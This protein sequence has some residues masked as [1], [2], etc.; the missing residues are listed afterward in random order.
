MRSGINELLGRPIQLEDI[1]D[2]LYGPLQRDEST[3]VTAQLL[4]T[5]RVFAD[6]AENIMTGKEVAER[7]WQPT[8]GL[9]LRAEEEVT[10]DTSHSGQHPKNVLYLVML[11]GVFLV[12]LNN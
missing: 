11:C 6:M 12:N 5:R 2:L 1:E 3:P 7:E 8:A 10:S 4:L 9:E